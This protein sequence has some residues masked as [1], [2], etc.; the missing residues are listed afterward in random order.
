MQ[1]RFLRGKDGKNR[2]VREK[3][4]AGRACMLRRGAGAFDAGVS[5]DAARRD[6]RGDGERRGA[7]LCGSRSV[8]GL[9]DRSGEDEQTRDDDGGLR[10]ERVG[11]NAGDR[12]SRL[13]WAGTR[14][15]AA[16]SGGDGGGRG[17]VAPAAKKRKKGKKRQGTRTAWAQVN[18]KMRGFTRF[19]ASGGGN[20]LRKRATVCTNGAE[21]AGKRPFFERGW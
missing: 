20:A 21:A 16:N 10:G 15:V 4:R 7:D 8:L 14:A 18:I 19:F 1:G 3:M 9:R 17:G 6:R 13:R 5:D 2:V 11:R 12:L